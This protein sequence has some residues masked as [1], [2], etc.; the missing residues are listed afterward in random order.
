MIYLPT[1]F[2]VDK[3]TTSGPVTYIESYRDNIILYKQLENVIF[4][5]QQDYFVVRTAISTKVCLDKF[6]VEE[7]NSRTKTLEFRF[8][9]QRI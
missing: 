3:D 7:F 4:W 9:T 8:D 2:G 1:K 5:F 6:Y